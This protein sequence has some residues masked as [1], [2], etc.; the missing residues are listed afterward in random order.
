MTNTTN[1]FNPKKTVGV[2]C[3]TYR[4]PNKPSLTRLY[5]IASLVEQVLNQNFDGDI[6][7]FIVDDSPEPHPFL[8]GLG[9]KLA[10]KV[11][12]YHIP[13]RNS[14]QSQ[15]TEELPEAS[16]FFPKDDDFE[17]DPYWKDII[18]QVEDWKKFL[19]FDY[20]FAKTFTVDMTQQ[21]LAS[22]PTIGM[23]KNFACGAY[24][25]IVGNVPDVF[26]YVDDDD[27]RSPDYI[28]TVVDGIKGSNFARMT[29]T[30]VH[31]IAEE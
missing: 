26:V 13:E 6:K 10:G 5:G 23:K 25:E 16:K 1:A 14:L 8:E 30:F 3:S 19:P 31:N 21:V 11:F 2:I 20:E 18:R 29:R 22:R 7:L 4:D 15:I 17:K 27:F 12:Y 9:D 28:Q 24:R